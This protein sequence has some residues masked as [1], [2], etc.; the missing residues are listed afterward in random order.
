MTAFAGDILTTTA[1]PVTANPTSTRTWSWL[2]NGTAIAGQTS[3]TYRVTDAD[4]GSAVWSRQTE[5]NFIGSAIASA[6]P[7]NILPWTPASL[8]TASEPGIWMDPSDVANLNWRRNLLT[9]TEQLDNSVWVK[10]NTTVTPN[11]VSAPD[12]T[13]TGDS[14]VV[15]VESTSQG[16]ASE[17]VATDGGSSY[18]ASIY[19]LK[20][21]GAGVPLALY[22]RST[23]GAGSQYSSLN[24]NTTT[25][26]VS[27][28]LGTSTSGS[29]NVQDAGAWWRISV[30]A[31][32]IPAGTIRAV[33]RLISQPVGTTIHLWGGQFEVGT[34]ASVYQPIT[35][36]EAATAERFPNATMFQDRAGSTLVTTPGQSVGLRLDKSKGLA[37]GAELR[38]TGTTGLIGTA[39][40][41]T[42]NTDTGEA[43]VS[44]GVDQSNQSFVAISGL[45]ASSYYKVSLTNTAASNVLARASNSTGAIL[46]TILAG[47]SQTFYV[48]GS[49][50]YAFT[51]PGNGLTVTFI[52]SSFK[53]IAG[54]HAVASADASRGVYG[55]EPFVG[56][57]NLL[58]RTEEFEN[59][60]WSKA[61]VT[62]TTNSSVAPDGTTTAETLLDTAVSNIHY[63]T[64]SIS[65][66]SPSGKTYTISA[67]LKASTLGFAT[68]GISDISSGTLYAVAVF[69]L[70]N[71][72]VSTAGAAGTG[73]SVSS[74]SI[75]DAGNGWY[76][77]VI[78]A[79]AGTSVSFLTAAIGVNKTGIISAGAGGMES[80]LG[81]GSGIL[82]WGAQ[83]ETGSTA[84][85]YQRVGDE[86]DVTE[87]G[88]PTLHYVQY[89]G[90]DDGY[91]T[92]TVTPG[93]DKVQVFAGMRFDLGTSNGTFIETSTA[94]DTN[95][96][97]FYLRQRVA[98]ANQFQWTFRSTTTTAPTFSYTLPEAAVLTATSDFSAP[99][100][101]TRRNGVQVTTIAAPS[102][103]TTNFLAYPIYI[104]RRGNNTLAFNGKDYGIV[105]RFGANLST[106]NI[107]RAEYYMAQKSGVTL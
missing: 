30:V 85:A 105:V 53:E 81:N 80:Y 84:T 17:L 15:T 47:T 2:R 83:L 34:S 36:L 37:L 66:L 87:A 59:A 104:G 38:Q 82:V 26:L 10:T 69:N 88:V 35:T 54:N 64:Q 51:A 101:V 40:A 103:G 24:I 8:F 23:L 96:G 33:V 99:L 22:F 31:G 50:Q 90:A 86:Y 18:A 28:S 32:G 98:G 14:L 41:A 102:A 1:A 19:V 92:P 63:A 68:L 4:V 107:N 77:C 52:L 100:T 95:N 70:S 106:T 73:Y 39:T 21:S 16:V 91:V 48:T 74:T 71:G 5:T 49:T 3:T 93:T 61:Q 7:L 46:A 44:R 58:V 6:V 45:S 43:S 89:D 65:A 78:T 11:T 72:T 27:F 76:R 94:A 97:A 57:R 29:Y 13:T 67:Y 79:V 75:S 62:V 9:F 60:S 55:V 42:Y 25:G 12:N 56:R 20:T